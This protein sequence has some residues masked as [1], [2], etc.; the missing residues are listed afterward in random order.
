MVQLPD[1]PSDVK[2]NTVQH[3]QNIERIVGAVSLPPASWSGNGFLGNHPSSWPS[4]MRNA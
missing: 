1:R 4:A 2:L 3:L